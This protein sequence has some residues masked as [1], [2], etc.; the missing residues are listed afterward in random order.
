[1][2]LDCIHTLIPDPTRKSTKLN[3]FHFGLA[4]LKSHLHNQ[5]VPLIGQ[6]NQPEILASFSFSNEA[7]MGSPLCHLAP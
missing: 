4:A 7:K 1:M 3:R 5:I 2:H 6:I